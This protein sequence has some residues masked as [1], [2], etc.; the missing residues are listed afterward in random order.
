MVARS[1]GRATTRGLSHKSRRPARSPRVG[2]DEAPA[3]AGSPR[4]RRRRRARARSAAVWTRRPRRRSRWADH[5]G[6]IMLGRSCWAGA[7]QALVGGLLES[8]A[9]GRYLEIGR[10]HVLTP[11]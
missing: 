5:V 8:R 7:A 11:G 4:A 2:S 6:P 9:A 3:R 10:G 1:P